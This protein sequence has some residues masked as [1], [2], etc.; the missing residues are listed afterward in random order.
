MTLLA[1]A[2]WWFLAQDTK[3]ERVSSIGPFPSA[4]MCRLAGDQM[5]D[6]PRFWTAKRVVDEQR[7]RAERNIAQR[8][9]IKKADKTPGVWVD[10]GGYGLFRRIPSGGIHQHGGGHPNRTT[11]HQALTGCIAEREP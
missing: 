3:T 5:T 8:T 10:S 9:A 1:V 6:D 4:D 11:R 2:L 7:R